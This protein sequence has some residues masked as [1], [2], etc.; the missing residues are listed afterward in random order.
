APPW[1][2]ALQPGWK[3]PGCR[4]TRVL[5]P[6]GRSEE[7]AQVTER[8]KSLPAI[9]TAMR[10]VLGPLLFLG[11]LLRVP[12]GW[13]LAA[14]ITALLS[15][16]FDGV[17]A[18]RLKVVTARLREADSFTDTLFIG[19]MAGALL[20]R[21]RMLL[22][23]YVI[24]IG[25]V[26]FLNLLA[27]AAEIYKY[28]RIASYHTYTAKLASLALFIAVSVMLVNNSGGVV[29][30]AALATGALCHI[31]QLLIT[32]T[33]PNWTHDVLSVFHALAL[34]A[35]QEESGVSG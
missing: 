32:L 18:R 29:V 3:L 17:V 30:W 12:G 7:Y 10:A 14:L 13:L 9:L 8:L 6:N 15:D 1:Q 34:R 19:C 21:R 25:V 24:P 23:R 35:R 2:V 28:R 4:A 5:P 11:A 20:L 22:A 31:E 16:I 27:L 26:L 33:L